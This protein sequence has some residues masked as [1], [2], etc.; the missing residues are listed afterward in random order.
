MNYLSVCSGIEAATCA[1]HDLGW[2]PVGFS[3]I[4]KFPSE[5]LKH[6]Y[7]HVPN[8]GDMT[9]F[10]E[11]N[12]GTNVD[13]FVGGTPCQSFS[14]AG[15]RK[16]LDDPRGNLMLT[17][18]AIADRFRPKWLVWE[19]VP[20]VLSSNNGEDFGTF[21]GGLGEL[22]YGFAYR[23]LD[24]QYFGVAQRRRRVFVIGHLG[25]WRPAAAVLFERDSLQRNPPPS[26]K[27]R[28]RTAAFFESSL[29][30]YRAADVGGTLKASGGVLGGGSETFLAQRVDGSGDG[31]GVTGP[32]L[33]RDFKG[34]DSYDHTK[35]IPV[36]YE[37][38]PAD[39]RV[40]E[41]GDVCS[42]VTSRWGTGGGNVPFATAAFSI[43]EDAQANNF[44]ATEL[45]VATALKA[46]QPSVQ[47]HHA[48]T[49]VAQPIGV[50]GSEHPNAAV[51][52]DFTPTLTSAMGTGGGHVPVVEVDCYP[53]STQNALG[54]VNG[55]EDWPL[56]LFN[57]GDP[58]PTLT[59]AHGHAVALSPKIF[60]FDS[61]ESNSMKSSNPDSGCREVDLSK[62]LDT[63]QPNPA[64][65]QGGI[66]ILQP[67]AFSAID[68]GRDATEG[69]SP[70]L[71][72]GGNANGV[73]GVAFDT[74]NQTLSDVNQTIKSP[75]GGAN[76]SIGTVLAPA[77][78]TNNPSRS[79]QAS[80]VTQQVNA[81]YQASMAVRRLT[82]VECERLQGFPDGY[83]N[84][85]T[86]CPDGPRYKALGNSM[87][88]PVMKWIGQRIADYEKNVEGKQ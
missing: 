18:L 65:G 53:I 78:T 6:H 40:E 70:T 12:L 63:T 34:I 55:R 30:Q 62:T 29:A 33:A 1:W 10:K 28:E 43:R 20:G 48:Q 71:R 32:L 27:A 75:V 16:G 69:L 82:P 35:V 5:V 14:V 73:M 84:I 51:T 50:L 66:G 21:L 61:V 46:L 26:R 64:K 80:E 47:S 60:S 88:V 36:V 24:A 83:T 23:V 86:N 59:K 57:E 31:R 13:V 19:N 22:G 7:P 54:R 38:H 49:F 58:S 77:L 42:T 2:N 4:E 25:D 11:W 9:K 52:E 17:Y 68:D 15:L 41:M 67:I 45:E 76:E 79:P 37:N 72:V 85:R 8:L 87:A 44:S 74:Y 3:E 56:G 39:S 81:V